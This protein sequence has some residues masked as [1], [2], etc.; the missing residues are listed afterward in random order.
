M[1][2]ESSYTFDFEVTE[3]VGSSS[4]NLELPNPPKSRY[5]LIPSLSSQGKVLPPKITR[6]STPLKS[7]KKPLNLPQIL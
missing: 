2:D 3:K 4:T 5:P 7:N 6:E 1:E